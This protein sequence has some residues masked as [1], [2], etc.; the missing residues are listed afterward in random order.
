MSQIIT[1]RLTPKRKSL[2][3]AIKK[4]FNLEKN[5]EAIDLALGMSSDNNIDYK[6]RIEKV[7]GIVSLKGK[8]D[9]VKKIR[10]LR[11]GL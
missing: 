6:S 5:S 11:N 10:F 7:S 3:N 1:F 9:S 4:R 2:L 8:K